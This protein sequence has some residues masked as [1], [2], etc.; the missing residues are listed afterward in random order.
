MKIITEPFD[1]TPA[2]INENDQLFVIQYPTDA[3]NPSEQQL[4][5]SASP[6]KKVIGKYLLMV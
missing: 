4:M 6:C 5:I 3:D 2:P 1:L